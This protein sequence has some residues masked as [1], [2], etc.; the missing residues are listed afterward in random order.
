MVNLLRLV[1]V[2]EIM[3]AIELG[4]LLVFSRLAP[5]GVS[6]TVRAGNVQQLAQLLHQPRED[7]DLGK[8]EAVA[9]IPKAEV[10]NNNA[11]FWLS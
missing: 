5:L 8:P 3:V 10:V 9:V 4:R 1:E 2:A 11:A 6:L 7:P